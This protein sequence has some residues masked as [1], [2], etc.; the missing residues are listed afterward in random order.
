MLSMFTGG[1]GA[2]GTVSFDPGMRANS[3]PPPAKAARAA[4]VDADM[5]ELDAVFLLGR[6]A[7]IPGFFKILSAP[8]QA[9]GGPLRP[10]D[11]PTASFW[12]RQVG[13]NFFLVSAAARR[14][15]AERIVFAA[16]SHRDT[17]PGLSFCDYTP[18]DVSQSKNGANLPMDGVNN[19]R[20]NP[21]RRQHPF[22]CMILKRP[23]L[24]WPAADANDRGRKLLHARK[25]VSPYRRAQ[26]ELAPAR[27][28]IP[29]MWVSTATLGRPST[30]GGWWPAWRGPAD[31][32]MVGS[33]G[34]QPAIWRH[35]AGWDWLSRPWT[36][37]WESKRARLALGRPKFWM[38]RGRP[39]GQPDGEEYIRQRRRSKSQQ[40]RN[41]PA[42]KQPPPIPTGRASTPP[43]RQPSQM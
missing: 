15:R 10:R 36:L 28:R 9:D 39:A 25:I 8:I 35:H 16:Q 26:F 6:M 1:A 22:S 23:S 41:R 14:Q 31:R 7:R 24:A 29:R 20:S 38:E 5:N 17:R 18:A 32:T 3:D 11:I 21:Y 37:I 34:R 42:W 40:P 12:Q 33:V 30:P 43:N 27:R 19:G 13:Q 2:H 4:D